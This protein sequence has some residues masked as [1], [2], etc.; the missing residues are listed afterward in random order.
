MIHT[1]VPHD[2]ILGP[3]L[4]AMYINDIFYV[5]ER[6]TITLLLYEDDTACIISHEHLE[7]D[8]K[9]NRSVVEES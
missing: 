3:V 5:S 4:C 2:S 9:M 6:P 1:D 7:E 8:L